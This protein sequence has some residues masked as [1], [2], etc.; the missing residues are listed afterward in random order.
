VP[1]T[2]RRKV[3]LKAFQIKTNRNNIVQY[4]KVTQEYCGV[5]LCDVYLIILARKCD[6]IPNATT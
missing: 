2:Y 1:T 6:A 5:M 3:L 4:E